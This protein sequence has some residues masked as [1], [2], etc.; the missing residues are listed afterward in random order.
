MCGSTFA[1]CQTTDCAQPYRAEFYAD[2]VGRGVRSNLVSSPHLVGRL[3]SGPQD[4]FWRGAC[5]FL[6]T[7]R[8][9]DSRFGIYRYGHHR[10]FVSSVRSILD[11]IQ[12]CLEC[13]RTYSALDEGYPNSSRTLS[14]RTMSREQ[15]FP[16]LPFRTAVSSEPRQRRHPRM[17]TS[18]LITPQ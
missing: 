16:S 11:T 9:P 5:T 7:E 13:Q 4:V 3:A 8:Q 18:I 1:F 15:P 12:K 10:K 14:R 17:R 2:V 6:R